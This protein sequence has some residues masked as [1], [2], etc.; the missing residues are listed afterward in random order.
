MPEWTEYLRPRLAAL[1]LD[2]A[3]EAEIIEE[4]SQHLDERYEELRAGGATD[5]EARRLAIEELSE[6]DALAKDMRPLRQAHVTQHITPG[7]S[8]GSALGNLRHDFRFALRSLIKNPGF[9]AVAIIVLALGIGANTAIFTV[10]N[11]V[12]LRPLPYYEA[13][14]LV[15]LWETDPRFQFGIDTLPVTHGNYMDW[16][17]QSSVFEHMCAFGT[18]R[19]SFTGSGEPERISGAS[20]SSNFFKLMGISARLGRTFRDDED[21]VGASKVVVISHALWQERFG[22]EQDVIGKAMTLDGERYA[23]IGVAPQGFHFPRPKDLPFFAGVS[24]QTDL[25]RPMPFGD[26][27]I[28][29]SRLDHQLNVIARLKPGVTRERAQS[30]M[31]LIVERLKR[32]FP[33]SDP[34]IGVKVVPLNEQVVGG[35][36]PALWMLRISGSKAV[37]HDVARRYCHINAAYVNLGGG[38][39]GARPP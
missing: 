19:W 2:P 24:I 28:K 23:V 38:S 32:S 35:V 1:R 36:R 27:F 15:M 3:R 13:D 18:G 20:V 5:A 34:R 9:T 4:L 26:A 16:R 22:G 7:A 21:S 6:A 29:K 31:D 12:L 33:G 17:E 14:R 39:P 25:W 8:G 11:A 30:E 37:V 10:V